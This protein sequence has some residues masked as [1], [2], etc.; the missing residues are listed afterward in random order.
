MPNEAVSREE[1][2]FGRIFLKSF[3]DCN[4]LN[5][6]VEAARLLT[7]KEQQNKQQQR[8]PHQNGETVHQPLLVARSQPDPHFMKR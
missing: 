2:N 5:G 8:I 7:F 3:E 4:E 6:Y 1:S